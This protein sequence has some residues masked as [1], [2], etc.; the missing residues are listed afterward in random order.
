MGR[1]H[2]ARAEPGD[3]AGE[4]RLPSFLIIGSMRS[5]TTALADHLRTHPDVFIPPRKELHFFS[6]YAGAGLDWYRSQFAEAREERAVGEASPNYMYLPDAPARMA[7]VVPEARLMAILRNPVDRAYSH[8]VFNRSRGLEPLSFP[9]ALE[10]EAERLREGELMDRLRY[11][12]VDRGRYLAQ[13]QRVCEHYPKGSLMVLVFEEF[14]DDPPAVYG[15]ACRFLEVDDSYLPA[16][17][18]RR[19]NPYLEFRS[20]RLRAYTKRPP[21]TPLKR[22]LARLNMVPRT[23]PSMDPAVRARVREVFRTDNAAL[24]DWLDRDLTLWER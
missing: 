1:R 16:D 11:S 5:G 3:L 8:Y 6:K 22:V 2:A 21:A 24:A 10:A 7:E 12:Y 15:S 20:S 23:Y 4:G 14:R 17:L 19:I 9:E 13:L 18:G